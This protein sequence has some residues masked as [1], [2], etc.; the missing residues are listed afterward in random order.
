MINNKKDILKNCPELE[1]T[2]FG[3]FKIRNDYVKNYEIIDFHC[4]IFDGL[5]M[6]F[7]PILGKADSSMNS[8]LF[9][10]SCF[11]FSI[12]SFDI[13][14]VYFTKWPDS[15]FSINGIRTKIKLQIGGFVLRK[16]TAERLLRDMSLNN[17]SK[18]VVM[19]IN[20]KNTNSSLKMEEIITSHNNL[21]TFGSIHPH[22]DNI[23]EKVEQ[24]ISLD[25]KGWKV[26]PHVTGVPI[27][28]KETLD[29]IKILSDTKLPIL[30]C[31]GLGA[32]EYFLN[33]RIFSNKKK[34]EL[35][36]QRISM[37]YDMLSLFPSTKFILAHCGLYES[38]ELIN[39]MKVF[40]NIYTDISA[41]SANNIKK[42][43]NAIGSERLLFGTDYP[44]FNHAFSIVSVLRATLKEEDRCNIFSRNA[45]RVLC[46]N[47]N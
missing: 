39:L 34:K 10:N 32:P 12:D 41:Q 3:D 25:I 20:P 24:Y 43:N 18:S 5:K 11:P 13:N 8:S 33:T 26:N 44:F 15:L 31:S 27:N 23:K 46:I 47:E 29:L 19:Q 7:P 2:E 38:D 16:A 17:I 45:T 36:T 21:M 22:D 28:S 6:M 9:D 4:H 40:P 30:S 37:F 1:L 42:I 14:K 35:E